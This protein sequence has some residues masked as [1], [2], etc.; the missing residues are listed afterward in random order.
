MTVKCTNYDKKRYCIVILT[1]Y[2]MCKSSI[3]PQSFGGYYSRRS[4]KMFATYASPKLCC[5]SVNASKLNLSFYQGTSTNYYCLA[6][7]MCHHYWHSPQYQFQLQE[8]WQRHQTIQ[9]DIEYLTCFQLKQG[10]RVWEDFCVFVI[11]D[12]YRILLL[13]I[14]SAKLKFFR[15]PTCVGHN[16]RERDNKSQNL[17]DLK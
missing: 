1:T 4:V 8:Q 3:L 16:N 9:Q 2:I 11:Y 5:Q 10:L 13:G 14:V 17:L 7:D 12:G 6:K 15:L